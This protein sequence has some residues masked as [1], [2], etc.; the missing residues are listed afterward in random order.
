MRIDVGAGPQDI[1]LQFQVDW[2]VF[3]DEDA[4]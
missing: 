1:V 2:Q 4:K 3:L